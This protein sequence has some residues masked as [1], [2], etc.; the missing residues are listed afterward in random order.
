MTLTSTDTSIEYAGDGT[1]TIFP[2]P[3]V[4]YGAG[5]IAV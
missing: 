4:F 2:V 3:F 1:T 5:D